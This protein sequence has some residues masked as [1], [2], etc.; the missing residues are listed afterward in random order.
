[1][2]LG[3]L[4]DRTTVGVFLR[5]AERLGDRVLLR[6]WT[7]EGWS[8][9]TWTQMRERALRVA[10]RLVEA[11]VQPGDR[12][13]LMGENSVQWL[14]CD[15]GIQLAGAATVPVYPSTPAPQ[16]A[17][18]AGDSESVLAIVAGAEYAGRLRGAGTLK[19]VLRM[20]SE[21]RQWL[22]APFPE[23]QMAEVERR[24]DGLRPDDVVS[25]IYTSG[26]TGDP[27]GVVL[28]HR[29]FVD[30]ASAC[31]A[32]FDIREDDVSLSFLPFSH[33]FGRINDVFVAITAGMSIYLSRGTDRLAED[34]AEVR[35]TVML[36]VPRLYE[37]MYGRVME[38][39]AAA[40]AWRRRLFGWAI[41]AGRQRLHGAPPGLRYR[42]ADRLVL[43]KLRSALTGGRL[44][45]FISGGAPLGTQVEEFF[46]AIG[47]RILQGYG[48]TESA[49]AAVANTET[50][51]RYGSVGRPLP[52]VQIRLADD[53]EILIRGPGNMLGYHRNPQA[54][55]AVL[56]DG[57]LHT[58]DIG[59][60]DGDGFLRVTDRKKDL[61]KTSGGKFVAPQPIEAKLQDDP[62][63][64]SA[65][66]IGDRRPYC[67]ALI[68]PNWEYLAG[69]LGL[70]GDP[71]SAA[72]HPSV[73]AYIQHRVDRV[74]GGLGSWE[75][76]K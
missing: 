27:K 70:T 54:T 68:V 10:G 45:F 39:V 59:E 9:V 18:I 34:L 64:E 16:A 48:L 58:G 1:M 51:H 66:V 4:S 28:A 61:I 76:I 31:L 63:I 41:A 73:R 53:G 3:R 7:G 29:S 6:H 44:R 5:Q 17:L 33:V 47:V 52:G 32:A 23:G 55:E 35:P 26:T 46:W 75:S 13:L 43:S 65:V 62:G 36:S 22:A 72:D 25:I 15:L 19:R 42:L 49:S 24:L 30:M 50:E 2:D 20:D 14:F 38:R 40:P 11:G 12:V 57:W 8:P 71:A 21:L 67:V 56:Q 37:K 74:N 69:H 60:L